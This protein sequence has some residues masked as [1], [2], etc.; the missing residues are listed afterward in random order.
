MVINHPVAEGYVFNKNVSQ[1]IE[2]IIGSPFM[3]KQGWTLDFAQKV[4]Y[5]RNCQTD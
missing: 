1:P 5:K 4:I 3:A 2:G